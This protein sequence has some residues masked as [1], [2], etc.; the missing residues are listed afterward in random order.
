MNATAVAFLQRFGPYVAITLLALLAWAE[1]QTI[2]AQKSAINGLQEHAAAV[3]RRIGE[4]SLALEHA[5]KNAYELQRNQDGL[6]SLLSQREID[7]RKLQNDTEELQEWADSPLPDAIVRLRQR[8]AITGSAAYSE[9][10]SSHH[11]LHAIGEQS[12]DGGRPQSTAG[13]SRE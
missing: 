3:G 4:I 13:T 6:R 7:I 11:P 10:L 1:H 5:K 12:A 8:P 9:Y 2:S